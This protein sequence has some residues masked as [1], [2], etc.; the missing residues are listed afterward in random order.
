MKKDD[1][2]CGKYFCAILHIKMSVLE[3][4]KINEKKL[5][6]FHVENYFTYIW[7]EKSKVYF[8]VY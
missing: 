8:L 7:Y 2:E 6:N 1:K 3:L 4:C 5:L